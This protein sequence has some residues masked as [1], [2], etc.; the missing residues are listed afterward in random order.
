MSP[1]VNNRRHVPV[2]ILEKEHF[3]V[4]CLLLNAINEGIGSANL[5]KVGSNLESTS[6]KT[7]FKYAFVDVNKY[8]SY[9]ETE[10]LALQGLISSTF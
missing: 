10:R 3:H 2:C 5:L 6:H 4:S 7:S 9:E 1:F 8:F